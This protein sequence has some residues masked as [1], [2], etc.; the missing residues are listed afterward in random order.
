MVPYDESHRGRYLR[1]D[2]RLL[3]YSAS[4]EL[5][6]LPLL[7]GDLLFCRDVCVLDA[8]EAGGFRYW[9]AVDASQAN[10]GLLVFWLL[11]VAGAPCA[12]A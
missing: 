1:P 8:D 3:C 10:E 7:S 6:R 12:S 4:G 9:R 2:F 5:S 11:C